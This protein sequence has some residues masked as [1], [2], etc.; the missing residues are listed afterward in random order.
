[1]LKNT[2]EILDRKGIVTFMSKSGQLL[3]TVFSHVQDR[4][5]STIPVIP[6]QECTPPHDGGVI[7][8]SLKLLRTGSTRFLL[9]V[10]RL[11]TIGS[12]YG[13]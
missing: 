8:E 4:E 2:P 6:Y 5:Y 3:W 9:R 10:V 12:V 7:L 13:T 1:M 11:G